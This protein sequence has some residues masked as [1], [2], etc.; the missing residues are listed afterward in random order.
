MFR[1]NLR[2]DLFSKTPAEMNGLNFI[3]D[4]VKIAIKE[5][6][7]I[8][9]RNSGHVGTLVN[10]NI[11]YEIHFSP[12]WEMGKMV[13]CTIVIDKS[14]KNKPFAYSASEREYLYMIG[15]ELCGGSIATHEMEL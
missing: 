8:E 9:R 1:I 11:D 7:F 6:A 4:A 14:K 10:G 12:I 2:T 3:K 15:W 13:S 5:S